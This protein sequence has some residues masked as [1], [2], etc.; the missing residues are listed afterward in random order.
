LIPY[1]RHQ[2]TLEDEQAVR[3]VLTSGRL[4]QGEQVERLEARMCE[5][6]GTKYAV[7]CSSGTAALWMAYRACDN[8]LAIQIPTLTFV[9]TAN[10]ALIRGAD[11]PFACVLAAVFFRH[12]T[13]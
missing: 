3:R 4:T 9:A 7:A 13:A 11:A 12:A 2:I 1:T 5:V 6:V 10:A 8:I